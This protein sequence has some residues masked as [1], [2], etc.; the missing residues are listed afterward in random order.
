MS[1]RPGAC[2]V[3]SGDIQVRGDQPSP[4]RAQA[5][6]NSRPELR[7]AIGWENIKTARAGRKGGRAAAGASWLLATYIEHAKERDH[8]FSSRGVSALAG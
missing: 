4:A 6:T 1:E 5:Y 2:V 3:L 8:S 7:G